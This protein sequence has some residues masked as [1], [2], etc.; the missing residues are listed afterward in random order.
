[1]DKRHRLI[2]PLR[3]PGFL[4]YAEALSRTLKRRRYRL[5]ILN[6][7]NLREESTQKVTEETILLGVGSRTTASNGVPTGMLA[8][9]RQV[10][11][12]IIRVVIREARV[13]KNASLLGPGDRSAYLLSRLKQKP[14][15]SVE[16]CAIF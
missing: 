15:N 2:M 12:R 11:L 3:A 4:Q 14:Q 10:N 7:R 16:E 1:M 5:P 9:P 13:E 6:M 8:E